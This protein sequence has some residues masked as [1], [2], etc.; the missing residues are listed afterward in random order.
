MARL[1]FT[2]CH[3]VS[4][5]RRLA[6][7]NIDSPGHLVGRFWFVSFKSVLLKV[8]RMT[9]DRNELV[10]PGNIL[11]T[12]SLHVFTL[13][14]SPIKN[15]KAGWQ[16]NFMYVYWVCLTAYRLEAVTPCRRISF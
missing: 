15:M 11:Y 2:A 12:W 4:P 8:A 16:S 7:K 10:D 14:M 13:Y 6:A 5:Q 1:D 3:L 9:L